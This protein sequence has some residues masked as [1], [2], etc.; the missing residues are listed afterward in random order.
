MT[1]TQSPLRGSNPGETVLRVSHC[2]VCRTDAKAWQKGHRDLTLPRVL[3]HEIAG[4]DE[5]T[6]GRF[7]VW[8]GRACGACPDC[9]AGHENRCL[10]MSILGFHR[11]GG[12]AEYVTVPESALIPIPPSLPGHLA[13]LAEPLAC[14]LN[15]L[16][17]TGISSGK[18]VLIF[19][20]GAVGLMASLAARAQGATAFVLEPNPAKYAKSEAFRQAVGVRT[21]PGSD[22]GGMDIAVSAAPS[23]DTFTEGL[24]RLKPGGRF[25]HFSAF[26]DDSPVPLS[27]I[28]DIH[29]RELQVTGAY[30]CTRNQMNG[31]LR[32]LDEYREQAALL[33]EETIDLKR[34]PDVLPIILSGQALKFVVALHP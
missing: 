4:I 19:G 33:I 12:F 22:A 32:L 29:Y 3:G 13:C 7:V 17:S 14:T 11:D 9:S 27:C 26:V 1:L 28:N 15:A 34:V 23:L 6:G 8:P 30:G 5:S 18:S 24:K 31:A 2:S 10:H 25:C 20:A 16:E 21:F